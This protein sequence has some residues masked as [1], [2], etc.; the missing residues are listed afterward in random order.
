MYAIP[1]WAQ[2]NGLIER[3]H[4]D[5]NDRLRKAKAAK[6]LYK[7][8]LD[9]K[10]MLEEVVHDYNLTPHS[11]TGVPPAQLLFHR[12]MRSFLPGKKG[13][14]KLVRTEDEV[15]ERDT[16]HKLYMEKYINE[17]R[18]AIHKDFEVGDS[19]VL[20]QSRVSKIDSTYR[21]E[22]FKVSDVQG[23][24]VTIQNNLGQVF[25]RASSELKMWKEQLRDDMAEE[26]LS[27]EKNQDASQENVN[28]ES[29]I[30]R[31]RR[32]KAKYRNY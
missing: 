16:E 17:K 13:E 26:E 15:R 18:K 14:W 19:V 12:V 28:L 5:L 1:L 2:S 7:Q 22:I 25:R 24:L 32:T 3:H 10:L 6:D 4:R 30:K 8:K 9:M 27:A 21:P 11:I 20:K 31:P 29:P 23:T